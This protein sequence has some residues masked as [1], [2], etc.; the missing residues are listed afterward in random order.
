MKRPM[1]GSWSLGAV[2]GAQVEMQKAQVEVREI[3][4]EV[5]KAQVALPRALWD[6]M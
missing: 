2:W 4:V 3:H 6:P 1:D 5:H